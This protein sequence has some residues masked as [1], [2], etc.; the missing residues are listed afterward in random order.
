MPAFPAPK[1][2]SDVFKTYSWSK[3]IAV[4]TEAATSADVGPFVIGVIDEA[5]KVGVQLKGVRLDSIYHAAVN[6]PAYYDAKIYKGVLIIRS[7]SLNDL[8]EFVAK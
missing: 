2:V 7:E 3:T 1:E 6:A 8:I 4:T 5:L